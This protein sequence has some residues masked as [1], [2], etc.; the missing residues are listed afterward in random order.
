MTLRIGNQRDFC[1]GLLLIL[2]GATAFVISLDYPMGTGMRMGPGYFPRILAGLLVGIGTIVSV[3]SLAGRPTSL[4]A[5]AIRPLL[6]VPAAI[7][8]FAG[9]INWLGIVLSSILAVVV[10]A[11]A[12][13]DQ[14]PLEIAIAAVLLSLFVTAIFV[15]GIGLNFKILPGL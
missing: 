3:R 1:A 12:A 6:L 5:F 2:I 14:R 10:A 8:I 11:V 13:K 4:P 15:G 7:I 9:S